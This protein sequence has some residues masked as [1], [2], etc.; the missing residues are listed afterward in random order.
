MQARPPISIGIIGTG[1]VAQAFAQ[2]WAALPEVVEVKWIWGRRPEAVASLKAHFQDPPE[3]LKVFPH[4]DVQVDCVVLATSDDALPELM[5]R[6]RSSFVL[7]FSGSAPAPR[8]GAVLWPIRAIS[9]A[10]EINWNTMPCGL[11]SPKMPNK[12]AEW[13]RMTAPNT[14]SMSSKERIGAH[15]T[16]VVVANF[17]NH[18][19]ALGQELAEQSGLDW[20]TFLPL[21]EGVWEAGRGGGSREAQTGPAARGDELTVGRHRVWLEENAPQLLPLYNTL[22]D[23]I[24]TFHT[25]PTHDHS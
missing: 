17:T 25:S 19:L 16:A 24:A 6:Y 9:G 2:R 23:S 7:H 1:R 10:D 14:Q 21:V 18:L 15:L 22:T 8:N 12:I 13:L 20:S 3:A 5:E 11:E 4:D